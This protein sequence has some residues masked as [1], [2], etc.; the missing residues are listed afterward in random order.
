MP[1]ELLEL[2]A[3]VPPLTLPPP[4]PAPVA[5]LAQPIHALLWRAAPAAVVALALA[6]VRGAVLLVL[7]H[8][9][10]VQVSQIVACGQARCAGG[11][12]ASF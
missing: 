9:L 10:Q 6:L 3:P 11:A 1:P 12:C 8:I 7:C 4:T 2:A 5:D